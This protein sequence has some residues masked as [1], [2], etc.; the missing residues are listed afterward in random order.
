M[1]D[2]WPGQRLHQYAIF[3]RS[4]AMLDILQG[5]ERRNIN[6]P[7]KCGRTPVYTAVSNNSIKSLEILLQHGADPSIPGGERVNNMTPLHQA[8]IE[9]KLDAIRLLLQYGADLNLCDKSGLTPVSLAR[10]I[11]S[12]QYIDIFEKEDQ[13]RRENAMRVVADFYSACE[14]GDLSK[15]KDIL[16]VPPPAGWELANIE[17]SGKGQTPLTIAILK[18]DPEITSELLGTITQLPSQ[19][20][21]IHLAVE[22]AQVEIVRQLLQ[23]FPECCKLKDEYHQL[24]FHVACQ[25]GSFEVVKLLLEWDYPESVYQS[26]LDQ[27]KLVEYR[28][29]FPIDG[30]TADGKSALY[31]ACEEGHEEI[32]EYLLN[33]TVKGKYVERHSEAEGSSDG[34]PSVGVGFPQMDDSEVNVKPVH[35]DSSWDNQNLSPVYL[36]GENGISEVVYRR[37]DVT[38]PLSKTLTCSYITVKNRHLQIVEILA[39]AGVRLDL[40][41]REKDV[42]YSLLLK[43]ALDNRDLLMLDKLL[44]LGV[45]DLNNFVFEEAVRSY[46][47]FIAHFLK[48]KASEDKASHINKKLMKKEYAVSTGNLGNMERLTSTDPKYKQ[49]FPIES[50]SLRWQNLKVLSTVEPVWLT[51]AVNMLNPAM[52]TLNERIPLFA[53]TRVN[54]SYNKITMVPIALLQLPSLSTLTV[55]HNEITEFPSQVN[56]TL[57]CQFLEELNVQFNNL[58][59]IPDYIFTLPRLRVLNASHNRIQNLPVSIWQSDYLKSVDL[60]HNIIENLPK[61]V[62]NTGRKVSEESHTGENLDDS[63]SFENEQSESS[64]DSHVTFHEVKRANH[65]TDTIVVCDEAVRAAENYKKG[66]KTLK[67]GFNCMKVF[68]E[69]LSCCC[70]Q[71]ESLEMQ[72][73]CLTAVGNLGAYP[74][75]LKMLDLSQNKIESMGDWQLEDD[76]KRCFCAPRQVSLV[77]SGVFGQ[78]MAVS[79]CLHRSHTKLEN[80]DSLDLSSNNLSTFIVLRKSGITHSQAANLQDREALEKDIQGKLLFPNITSLSLDMNQLTQLPEDIKEMRTLK[81]LSLKKNMKLKELPPALGLL[82]RLQ[83]IEVDLCPLEGPIQDVIKGASSKASDITGF[84]RSVLEE[85]E[86]YNSMNL[87]IVG[88]VGIG[89]TSLLQQL[90]RKGRSN[91]QMKNYSQRQDSTATFYTKDG[92]PLSTVG[93]DICQLFLDGKHGTVEFRTWD[94]AG[95]TEYYATHQYFL[96]PRSLY[97]V[98]WNL[99]RGEPGVDELRQWLVN[100]QAQAPGSPVIIV[101]THLDEIQVRKRGFPPNWE[102]SMTKLILEKYKR[103]DNDNIGL[104]RVI[105]IVNVSASKK[106][107]N[108]EKLQKKI[109]DTV[110]QLKHPARKT[111]AL[112]GHKVPKK[113]MKLQSVIT[114]IVRQRKNN[115]KEPVLDSNSYLLTVMEEM[116]KD[117]SLTG[118]RNKEDLNQATRFLH[119]NG[120]LCH[121]ED[122]SL[123]DQYFLDPQWLCDQLARVVS[124]KEVQQYSKNGVMRLSDMYKLYKDSDKLGRYILSLLNKFEVALQ[125]DN[126]HLLLPSLLPRDEDLSQDRT[127]MKEIPLRR[128]GL[129]DSQNAMAGSVY[130]P[131]SISMLFSSSNLAMRGEKLLSVVSSEPTTNPAFS[132]TRLY[133]LTYFPSGFWPRLITR[134]LADECF[135]EPAMK[136]YQFPQEIVERCPDIQKE[137]PS[138]RCWQTGFELVYFNN[139]IMQVKEVKDPSNFA[140]GMCDYLDE[141][142]SI[143]CH[144]DNEWGEL[145]VKD[146]VI[147]EISFKADKITFFL[148]HAELSG[149]TNFSCIEPRDVYHDEKAKTAV[150]A[151][152]VEHIDSLL[153]DWFPEIGESRFIQ[154][155]QGRYLVT[156][157]VLCPLCLQAESQHQKN[158]EGAWQL[159]SG[160]SQQSQPVSISTNQ[161]DSTQNIGTVDPEEVEISTSKRIMCTFLVEKCIKNVLEGLDEICKIHGAV[162]PSFMPGQDGVTRLIHIAPD[163]VFQDLDEAFVVEDDVVHVTDKLGQGAFGTVSKGVLKRSEQAVFDV[164]VKVLYD[165]SVKNR[166]KTNQTTQ[167]C[168]ETICAAYTTARQE[169]SI[170]QTVEHPHIVPLLGLSRR[171]LALLLSLAP[172][173]SLNSIFEDRHKDGL[174]LQVWVIKQIVIQVADALHYLHER[175]I[176]YRDLKSDNVLAWN[177]PGPNDLDPRQPVLVKLADYGISKSVLPGGTKGFGGT[178]PFIAPEILM[179]TGRDTYTEKVD[180]FS[181]GMFMFELLTCRQPLSDVNNINVH[182]VHGGRPTLKTEEAA[183]PSHML[184]LMNICW[185]HDPE[186]RPSAA[187]IRLIAS[188]PQFCHLSDAVTTETDSV[189]LSACS[190]FVENLGLSDTDRE[191]S[192]DHSQVWL[193]SD[194]FGQKQ[195]EILSFST[196]NKCTAYQK[197]KHE[198]VVL[199]VCTVEKNI[200]CLDQDGTIHIYNP[201][202][203]ENID[204]YSLHVNT[205]KDLRAM[206]YHQESGYVTIVV[207]ERQKRSASIFCFKVEMLQSCDKLQPISVVGDCFCASVVSSGDRYKL[208][209]G[210]ANSSAVVVRSVN[211]SDE[212]TRS[213]YAYEDHVGKQNTCF[214]IAAVNIANTHTAWTYNYPGSKVFRWDTDKEHVEAVLDCANKIPAVESHN[215]QRMGK[216]EANHYQVTALA[217]VGKYLYVATTWGCVIVADAVSM[218]PY[219]VF[220]CHSAE[221]FYCKAI[222][223]LGPLII[224]EQVTTHS[225]V[226]DQRLAET[227]YRRTARQNSLQKESREGLQY[228]NDKKQGIVTVGCGYV[229]MINRVTCLKKQALLRR[230]TQDGWSLADA[231]SS[232]EETT[233]INNLSKPLTYLLTWEP[234]H[235]EYY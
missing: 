161:A 120:V 215:V 113:Y 59:T 212:D 15:V 203:M 68:P 7:D 235:W 186:C 144:F 190:V 155:C 98:V 23:K 227:L 123:K 182:V 206:S 131:S 27:Q 5:E 17:V 174:R 195:I 230:D 81:T 51:R 97:L 37:T 117:D 169:V 101:G 109:Y 70:P 233:E 223:Q 220:R 71:L 57:G 119:E 46:P 207:K 94:F 167:I 75:Q 88:L 226:P 225:Q 200:W 53:V 224:P 9:F 201:S 79:S 36:T 25:T 40:T 8:L 28:L 52:T 170:L 166:K 83:R 199:A 90:M 176:I 198:T 143:E 34:F 213:I 67:L 105:D 35:I 66:L 165:P 135:Y 62:A 153:Q 74:R 115:N 18:G 103:I 45:Q 197:L 145:D 178:P 76:R 44:S 188:S 205:L 181:F 157:V 126:E 60:S 77:G 216:I 129:S 106:A 93:I 136:M 61:P 128:K 175:S 21:I 171:P 132:N 162:S 6:A 140:H 209:H 82:E 139:V 159:Y 168:L 64:T 39:S 96:S 156:R 222:L 54:V 187:H 194:Y 185:A 124:I 116:S 137:T 217:V 192:N 114:E 163:A 214:I 232:P 80:L 41:A 104:P 69:F 184:D 158:P 160:V 26:V 189:V 47:D 196:S 221:E 4:D 122:L 110:F 108:I 183:Y 118:F 130:N 202:K 58:P 72:K 193:V 73:N 112:L 43:L 86:Q 50:V 229:D 1:A 99:T 234:R 14:E 13:R 150:L 204:Q 173:G 10:N 164:A 78:S 42:E 208:W 55:A 149:G 29:P 56:F 95:Q 121:F 63:L 22:L 89:K 138:W 219:S 210:E 102:A 30:L 146:S 125:F 87:M 147:L 12:Q 16:R 148:G 142:L 85:S 3:D 32:V 38:V 100:I 218:E 24:P 179:H 127:I 211:N 133:L 49:I 172:L 154:S 141:N 2:E 33:F 228:E 92:K 111:E 19:P 152:I 191:Q 31:L 107:T 151:K 20:S 65:W 134:I 231:R 48:Y 84:L 177:L 180:I 91:S 11:G